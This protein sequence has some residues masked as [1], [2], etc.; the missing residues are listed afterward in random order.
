MK[1]V[2]E[3]TRMTVQQRTIAE[4]NVDH[5]DGEIIVK[6]PTITNYF[7]MVVERKNEC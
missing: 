6:I 3:N 2:I 5:H 4:R 7:E 1:H